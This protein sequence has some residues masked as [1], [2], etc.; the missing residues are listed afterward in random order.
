MEDKLLRGIYSQSTLSLNYLCQAVSTFICVSPV[1]GPRFSTLLLLFSGVWYN[2]SC[3]GT[4]FKIFSYATTHDQSTY[5]KY[6]RKTPWIAI[7]YLKGWFFTDL[8]SS[9]PFDWILKQW[10]LKHNSLDVTIFNFMIAKN[11]K[12]L[13]LLLSMPLFGF[14]VF[15]IFPSNNWK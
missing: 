8:L 15:N 11:L 14:K 4:N 3:E 1:F 2:S 9:I 10:Y 5:S 13:L 12:N 7:N 6:T